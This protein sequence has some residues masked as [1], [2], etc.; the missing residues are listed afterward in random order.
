MKRELDNTTN[1]DTKYS[2]QMI[3]IGFILHRQNPIQNL[4]IAKTSSRV[5]NAH[6]DVGTII[7]QFRLS[8]NCQT[9][10]GIGVAGESTQKGR[11]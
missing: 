9:Q 5:V 8:R 11:H 10:C 1:N 2:S 7:E 3:P 6:A 4:D